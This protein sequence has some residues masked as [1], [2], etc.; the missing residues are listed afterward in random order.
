MSDKSAQLI[1]HLKRILENLADY[2]RTPE[3]KV[4]VDIR[5]NE[6]R[7]IYPI[8]SGRFMR[9][10]AITAYQ[11]TGKRPPNNILRQ[12]RFIS[13]TQK[14]TNASSLILETRKGSKL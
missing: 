2:F 6:S 8:N 7:K 5:D 12:A 9:L 1:E 10:F 14:R 13:A 11:E 3:G 4:F